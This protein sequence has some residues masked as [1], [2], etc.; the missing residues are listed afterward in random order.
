[1]LVGACAG[2]WEKNR[3][4]VVPCASAGCREK[5][6]MLVDACASCSQKIG[7]QLGHVVALNHLFNYTVKCCYCSADGWIKVGFLLVHVLVV[8]SGRKIL[9]LLLL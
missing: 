8:A 9:C 6:W 7:F 3:I 2:C 5:S 1:M 4:L